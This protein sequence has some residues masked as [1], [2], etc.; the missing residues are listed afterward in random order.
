[1]TSL[2]TNN[3]TTAKDD[4]IYYERQGNVWIEGTNLGVQQTYNVGDL[5][6]ISISRAAYAI[7]KNGT[8]VNNGTHTITGELTPYSYREGNGLV[9]FNM[10]QQ[11]FAASNVTHDIDAGT[12]MLDVTPPNMAEKWSD[13]VTIPASGIEGSNVLA[14]GFDGNKSTQFAC[15]NT[16]DP[17]VFETTLTGVNSIKAKIGS[18]SSK[19]GTLKAFN[20]LTELGSVTTTTGT[21]E[22]ELNLSDATVTKIEV[23]RP[24]AKP[25]WFFIEINDQ[26]L[27]D[28]P[29]NNSQNWSGQ[30]TPTGGYGGQVPANAFNGNLMGDGWGADQDVTAT[31]TIPGG[32]SCNSLRLYINA[33]NGDRGPFIV[34]GT[35]NISSNVGPSQQWTSALNVTGGILNSIQ[36]PVRTS[37]TAGWTLWAVEVDGK[38]L[39]D[40]MDPGPYGTLFQTWEEWATFGVLLYDENHQRAIAASDALK[41]YGYAYSLPEAGV[42]PLVEQPP[43]PVSAYVQQEDGRYEAIESAAPS[44]A[45][46]ASTQQTLAST[47]N[48]L[49]ETT[50]QLEKT[51]DVTKQLIESNMA[52]RAQLRKEGIAPD[53]TFDIKYD[54]LGF[55]TGVIL[56][57]PEE[58]EEP[59]K[60]ARNEDGTYRANDP[61]TPENEAW[62]GGE[63]PAKGKGSK[64][65][66]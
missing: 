4:G 16:N 7:Y 25:G 21:S 26:I 50:A 53:R 5:I 54:D 44:K 24:G 30:I 48:D 56:P 28:G 49:D 18:D 31:W 11:P 62:E 39:I 46:L 32:I 2:G 66:G 12:V 59:P 34:N 33:D 41:T 22:V 1:M 29:A 23:S 55:E 17:I 15:N 65:K 37:P 63:P 20:N 51:Q 14:N 6:G 3:P 61:N 19:P 10:G 57:T 9:I 60:R 13:L 27:V 42:Q 64:K 36:F 38:I 45:A 43:Y 35:Q 52:F 40:G 58:E 47:Q 8:L